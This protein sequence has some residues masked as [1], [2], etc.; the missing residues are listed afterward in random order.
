MKKLIAIFLVMVMTLAMFAGCSSKEATATNP[1]E[2]AGA[3]A[4]EKPASSEETAGDASDM[5]DMRVAAIF[6]GPR[7]DSGTIDM[8]CNV[9]EKLEAEN[10]LQIEIVEGDG[11]NDVAKLTAAV[12]DTADE[13]YNMILSTGTMADVF[14]QVGPDYPETTFCLYDT[15]FD[16]STYDGDNLYCANFLQ[17]EGAYLAGMLAMSMSKTGT[18]GFIGGMEN[19]N[20]CDFMWGYVEGAKAVNP[21]GII[22]ISFTGDWM[23][24]AKAK[25]IC[26]TQ[27]GM[28]ADVVYPASGPSQEGAYEGAAEAGIYSIGVDVDREALYATSNP[29]WTE[30]IL[31]SARKCIDAAVERTIRLYA[32]GELKMGQEALGIAEGGVDLC[33]DG[34]FKT[35]VPEDVQKTIEDTKEAIANGEI[36]I[37]TA[38]GATADEIA[39]IKEWAGKAE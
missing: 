6:T 5:S 21:K 23:D 15:T 35:L 16:F 19:A 30:H 36:T 22:A 39:Q 26:L 14:R 28:K 38:I 33:L 1:P 4:A 32:A 18:I 24:S 31:T 27:A 2:T 25:E 3:P 12:M 29:D 37:G 7:G 11:T 17:N 34:N 13:G 20:I 10:G 9:L 8:V